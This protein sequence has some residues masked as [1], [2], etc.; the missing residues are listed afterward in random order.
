M[1]DLR[2]RSQRGQAFVEFVLLLP[3]LVLF[4]MVIIDVGRIAYFY[5]AIQNAAREGARYGAI[6][7]N[8]SMRTVHIREAVRR[9]TASL[10][11]DDMGITS[12]YQWTVNEVWQDSC[13]T[14]LEIDIE[15]V[16]VTVT[17]NFLPATPI[18]ARLFDPGTDHIELHTQA[19]MRL[20]R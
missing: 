15:V 16:C 3:I 20:E 5:S 10:H 14:V 6:H 19:T 17:Y 4:L 12:G 7:W 1:M 2:R 11:E 18:L 9:L 13:P 8:D